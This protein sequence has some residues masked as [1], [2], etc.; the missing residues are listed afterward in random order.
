MHKT[1]RG[2]DKLSTQVL[3]GAPMS[4]SSRLRDFMLLD[5]QCV[6]HLSW[7]CTRLPLLATRLECS[8][9]LMHTFD[10]VRTRTLLSRRESSLYYRKET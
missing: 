9:A 7:K 10:S 8:A 6:V 1:R 4:L 2:N 3:R 5:V